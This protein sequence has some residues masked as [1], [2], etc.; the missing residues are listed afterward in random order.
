LEGN[1]STRLEKHNA[2]QRRHFARDPE[3][4]PRMR[5]ADTPY[6]QRHLDRVI[7]LG[8]IRPEDRVLDVGCGMGKFTLPLLARGYDVEGL[9]LSPD[10][11]A[12]LQARLPEGRTVPLHCRDLA[13]V[14]P[15]LVGRFDVVT[16][17]FMLHHLLDLTAS[18]RAM[19]SYL[20]PGG[21]VCFVEPNAFNPLYY[22]Q[23]TF[24]PKMSWKSDKG[25]LQMTRKR[26]TRGLQQA[27]YTDVVVERCGMLPPVLANRPWGRRFEDAVD[28]LGVLKPVSAFQVITAVSP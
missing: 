13:D 22:L 21:R 11:L 5:P 28:R 12:R 15:E 23:I 14:P 16:G 10:Q 26:L 17:F 4:N 19:R 25:V 9:D 18:F 24:T 7:R 27:G 1:L 8:R 20:R 3:Q 6:V 2:V